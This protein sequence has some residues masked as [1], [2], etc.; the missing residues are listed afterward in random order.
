MTRA[1]PACGEKTY[2]LEILASSPDEDNTAPFRLVECSHCRLMYLPDLVP[3]RD[4]YSSGYYGQRRG[5]P[6]WVFEPFNRYWA[7]RKARRLMA[8]TPGLTWLD[9]GCGRGDLLEALASQG[10]DVYGIETQPDCAER[11][12]ARWKD[13]VGQSLQDLKLAPEKLDGIAFYHVLE[14]LE[15]PKDILVQLHP[16]SRSKSVLFV[17]V[18][19]WNAW[20]RSWF[21]DRWFHLDVPRHVQH[22]TPAALSRLLEQTGWTPLKIQFKVR[23]YDVFGLF[24]SLLNIGPGPRNYFY[25]RFK[26]GESFNTSDQWIGLVWNL[27][28]VLPAAAGALLV[29]PWLACVG[30]TG[31]FEVVA[32]KVPSTPSS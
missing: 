29:T 21:G 16:L 17:A 12:S 25:R 14:H 11:L 22:F 5:L 19:N 30:R 32:A 7:R 18:P 1:C 10:A 15:S 3:P 23:A 8:L 28:A 2:G 6:L 31:T 13:H 9:Y 27:I 24:Q 26:R 20:E 4:L